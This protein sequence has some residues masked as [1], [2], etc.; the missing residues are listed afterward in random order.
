MTTKTRIHLLYPEI[1]SVRRKLHQSP[2]LGTLEQKTGQL[3]CHYL[4]QWGISFQYPVADT[5]IV[6]TIYGEGDG[7]GNTVGLRADMDA[8]PIT[9]DA[10]REYGSQNPGVMHAC[11]HDIHTTIA[12]F[13]GKVLHDTRKQWGG[14]VKL[15]FQPAEETVGGAK[16]MI[17]A[18]CMEHPHV[19]YVTGLH[20][21]SYYDSGH[22]EVKHG[23][24]NAASDEIHITVTGKGC[25][26]AYPEDG[27]DAIVTAAALVTSLQSLVSRNLSPLDQGVLTFG[28]IRGGTAGNIVANRVVLTGTLRTTDPKTREFALEVI[29][30]QTRHICRA[31]GAQGETVIKPG[32]Q[33]LTNRDEITDLLVETA[34]PLL[35]ADHIHRKEF[36]SLGVEDFSFFL[37]Q[38]PGVFYHLG[39][40]NKEEGITAPIH[41][42]GFDCDETCMKTGILLQTELALKLLKHKRDPQPPLSFFTASGCSLGDI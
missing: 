30:R 17:A 1:I 10:G 39:C 11:G 20:V 31:Y 15:F 34:I 8:L 2:E 33:A 6:A 16:R 24:L 7:G 3:I 13:S 26:G 32:Y 21:A 36:P 14:C 27:V 12:L 28:M 29:K 37:E 19:D 22:I 23:K 25:H 38:A 35:G 5:G 9:E 40:G 18:G 42:S 4:S 41:T